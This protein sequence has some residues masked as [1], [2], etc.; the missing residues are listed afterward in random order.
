MLSGEKLNVL[1][2]NEWETWHSNRAAQREASEFKMRSVRQTE[3]PLKKHR[4]RKSHS[5]PRWNFSTSRAH[6]VERKLKKKAESWHLMSVHEIMIFGIPEMGSR[7]GFQGPF[8]YSWWICGLYIRSISLECLR[9]HGRGSRHTV[10]KCSG[11]SGVESMAECPCGGQGSM[12]SGFCRIGNLGPGEMDGGMQNLMPKQEETLF[13]SPTP[14][15]IWAWQ[16]APINPVLWGQ[17]AEVGRSL[18]LTGQLMG[19]KQRA[20]GLWCLEMQGGKWLGRISSNLCPPYMGMDS[21]MHTRRKSEYDR[22]F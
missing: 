2:T 22:T 13:G 6:Q 18:E 4:E 17:E 1:S 11:S 10:G 21:T 20:L 16:H 8:G 15:K 19:F 7:V 12:L 14:S 9:S 3:Q 5:A